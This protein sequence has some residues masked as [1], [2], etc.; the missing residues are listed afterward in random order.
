MTALL[1]FLGVYAAVC[2]IL[3]AHMTVIICKMEE[4]DVEQMIGKK[5]ERN[6][7]S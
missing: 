2:T 3:L 6:A 7:K 1:V 5:E 4:E